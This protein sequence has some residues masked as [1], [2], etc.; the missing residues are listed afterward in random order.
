MVGFTLREP[1]RNTCWNQTNQCSSIS[2]GN[3]P[4]I[5]A[6]LVSLSWLVRGKERESV[7]K[8]PL[9]NPVAGCLW[10]RAPTGV[11]LARLLLVGG[12]RE[13][14]RDE[15]VKPPLHILHLPGASTKAAG[16]P[17]ARCRIHMQSTDGCNNASP[18]LFFIRVF[19][20]S[21]LPLSCELCPPFVFL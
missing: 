20:L 10:V 11:F 3:Q 2:S 15:S 18:L 14:R 17:S 7:G 9:R 5:G 1:Q 8:S 16:A 21:F 13:E 19:F 12:D 4:S 6:P